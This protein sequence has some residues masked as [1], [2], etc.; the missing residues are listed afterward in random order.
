MF[1]DVLEVFRDILEVFR[2]VLETFIAREMFVHLEMFIGIM[3]LN[4]LIKRCLSSETMVL[5]SKSFS[6]NSSHNRSHN[7]MHNS[8]HCLLKPLYHLFGIHNMEGLLFPFNSRLEGMQSIEKPKFLCYQ[9][10][11]LL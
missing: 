11:K 10:Q 9:P 1:R 6:F 4:I 7:S 8:I 5:Q 3:L 2:V